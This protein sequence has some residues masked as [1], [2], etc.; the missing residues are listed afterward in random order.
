MARSPIIPFGVASS[1]CSFVVF[2]I[3]MLVFT[4][5][6]YVSMNHD[7]ASMSQ[8]GEDWNLVPIIDI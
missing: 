6:F 5:G 4:V 7:T 3:A 8:I 1:E 2:A